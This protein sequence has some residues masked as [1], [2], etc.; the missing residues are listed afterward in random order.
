MHLQSSS[1]LSNF[2]LPPSA[3]SEIAA[4]HLS[5]DQRIHNVRTGRLECV[6]VNLSAVYPDPQNP[7]IEF[8][9]EELRAAKRGW[10]QRDWAAERSYRPRERRFGDAPPSLAINAPLTVAA[11]ERDANDEELQDVPRAFETKLRL[12]DETDENDENYENPPFDESESA[13]SQKQ[14]DETAKKI[15]RREDRATRTRKIKVREVK[16]ETQTST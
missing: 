4:A 13:P 7:A 9:F 16:G 14:K 15:M 6:A 3:S 11:S 12:N 2:Q 1:L 10:L 8:C 5:H